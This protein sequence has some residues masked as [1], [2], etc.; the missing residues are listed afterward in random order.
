MNVDVVIIGGSGIGAYSVIQ[1]KDKGKK[2]VVV[3]NKAHTET[4]MDAETES[5][6]IWV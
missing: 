6:S 1:L 2:I 4:Y 3:E 5:P